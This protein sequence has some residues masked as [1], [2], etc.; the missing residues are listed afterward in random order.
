M[1]EKIRSLIVFTLILA[2]C[3]GLCSCGKNDKKRY[4]DTSTTRE[5]TEEGGSN[6]GSLTPKA[7][8]SRVREI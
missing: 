3:L 2:M 7:R 8:S 6:T 5:V 1:N 4:T